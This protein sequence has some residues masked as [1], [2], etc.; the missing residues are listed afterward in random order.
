MLR[1]VVDVSCVERVAVSISFLGFR[2]QPGADRAIEHELRTAINALPTIRAVDLV[3]FD[4][5]DPDFVRIA[6]RH[7]IHLP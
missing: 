4:R 6:S 5:A 2:L 7:V 1:P 3:D